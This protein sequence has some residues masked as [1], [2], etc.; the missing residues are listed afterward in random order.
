MTRKKTKPNASRAT[1]SFAEALVDE[2][3]D[4]LIALSMDGRVL[5]WNRGAEVMFGFTAHDAIG[6]ALEELVVPVSERETARAALKR[7]TDG[8]IVLVG[9]VR[10]RKD[11]TSFDVAVSMRKVAHDDV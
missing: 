3:P 2:S 1:A 7:A 9:A 5:S 11:G 4:A 8:E 10:C 6:E